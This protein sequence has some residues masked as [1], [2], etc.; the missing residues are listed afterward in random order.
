[1]LPLF[2]KGNILGVTTRTPTDKDLQTC[3]HITCSS[4]RGWDK[5]NVRGPKSL[6]TA[7]EEISNNMGALMKKGVFPGLADTGSDSNSLYQIYDIGAMTSRMIGSVKFALIPS[8]NVSETKATV[9][10]VP[11]SKTFQSKGRH[12]TV[13]PE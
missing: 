6:R 4:A 12:S 10:D 3:I 13:S 5:K 8:R 9:Q 7:E 11:H 1:M 2:S